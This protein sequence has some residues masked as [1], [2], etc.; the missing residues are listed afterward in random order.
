MNLYSLC[1][2]IDSCDYPPVPSEHYSDALRDLVSQCIIADPD[3][4]PTAS[5]VHSVAKT[6]HQKYVILALFFKKKIAH[7]HY[8]IRCIHVHGFFF[9]RMQPPSSA[10]SNASFR[11][12]VMRRDSASESSEASLAG[13][14]GG[15]GNL[16]IQ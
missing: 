14:R 13:L 10:V 4:R 1:K 8:Y 11:P 9:F 2:K 15:L 3:Q 5:Y 12:S 16:N 7:F 6:M